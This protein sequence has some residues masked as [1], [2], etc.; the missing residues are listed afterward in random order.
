MRMK[1]KLLIT[2]I[3]ISAFLAGC[4]AN[5]TQPDTAQSKDAYIHEI[6]SKEPLNEEEKA[7]DKALSKMKEEA[8]AL[9]DSK[10]PYGMVRYDDEACLE[11]D[12]HRFCRALPKGAELHSQIED[13]KELLD[14]YRSGDLKERNLRPI[15]NKR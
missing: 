3:I 9:Y 14:A 6:P 5:S 2:F 1:K 15:T 10:E 12:M 13:L 8:S 7:L 11:S 4:G